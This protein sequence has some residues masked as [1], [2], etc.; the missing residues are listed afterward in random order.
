LTKKAIGPLPEENRIEVNLGMENQTS[1]SWAHWWVD[2]QCYPAG[3][4]TVKVY[5]NN[6]V[7]AYRTITVHPGIDPQF[8]VSGELFNQGHYPNDYIG[9][10]TIKKV[11]CGLVSAC[12]MLN[13]YGIAVTP[14]KLNTWLKGHGGYRGNLINFAKPALIVFI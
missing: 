3:T 8:I 5:H 2:M 10:K 13:Y 7:V 11:G 14:D 12:I 1:L 6:N 9:T 4:W